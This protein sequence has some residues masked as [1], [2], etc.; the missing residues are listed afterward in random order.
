MHESGGS[1]TVTVDSAPIISGG[2]NEPGGR[3]IDVLAALGYLLFATMLLWPI[4][5][6][7]VPVASDTL[8]LWAPWSQ[9]PHEPVNTPVL[10]DSS[11]LYLPWLVYGR[12]SVQSG[13]WPLWDPYSFSGFPYAAN[14]QSQLYYP[15]T[16]LLWLLPLSGHI[17]VL[18]LFNIWLAGFGTYLFTKRLG[19]SRLAAF[20][21]GIAFAGS[22]IM[23]LVTGLWGVSSV[24]GWLPWILYFADRV[25]LAR[26]VG[27]IAAAAAAVALQLVAGHLQYAVYTIFV[28]A[29]WVVWRMVTFAR[30][31]GARAVANFALRAAA[32]VALGLGAA[33]VHLA[34]LFELSALSGR[35]GAL[36]SSNSPPLNT[37]L[38]SLAPL[39][40]GD[41]GSIG[42]PLVFNDLWYAGVPVVIVAVSA[43]FAS[44]RALVW[45]WAGLAAVAIAVA[46][47]IGPFLY[48]RWL[49]GL[50]GM[51]PIRIGY[52]FVFSLAVLSALGLDG[53]LKHFRESQRRAS[54]V[55]AV[56][57]VLGA[58]A[59]L[60]ALTLRAGE[61]DEALRGLQDQQVT[62]LA[63]LCGLTIA[64]LWLAGLAATRASWNPKWVLASSALLLALLWFDLLTAVRGYNTFVQ[65]HVIMPSSPAV[66]WLRS[67]ES[68]GRMLG[69][70]VEAE[71]P[72][73]VP[74]TQVL[75]R[76][77]SVAGY[78]S[79]HTR[80][81]EDFW[82]AFDKTIARGSGSTPYANV[83]V[84]PQAYTSTAASLL[85]VQYVASTVPLSASPGMTLAYEGEI[86]IYELEPRV[87]RAYFIA[88]AEVLPREALLTGLAASDFDPTAEVL[89]SAAET[90]PTRGD[91]G[92][93]AG[94]VPAEVVQSGRNSVDVRLEA[95]SAGWLVL[96]DV[97][98]PGWSATVNGEPARVY[99]AYLV[100]RTV[101]VQAGENEVHFE[102]R[103]TTFGYSVPVSMAALGLITACALMS[104]WQRRRL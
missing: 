54:A 90:P 7:R 34:P 8:Y 52:V 98:Y 71:P 4:L 35:I 43:L 77:P 103:P 28:L 70:G 100:L 57:F 19:A 29:V 21:A 80:D 5:F 93:P 68:D 24:Y 39:F 41:G 78:D 25:L 58:L 88:N 44:P 82:A 79:L 63:V 14:S 42:S 67:R 13:E 75:Y 40:L 46:Y 72:V 81:Y 38:R 53:L 2:A 22:G 11:L 60:S 18:S 74:N 51:L 17:Q 104:V 55:L 23:Q 33:L 3:R 1:T 61:A 66:D 15:L 92:A 59:I 16:W 6:G 85:D 56:S 32:V 96:G 30:A 10:A 50:S 37:L 87:P 49:P 9:T 83:F 31:K 89:L 86:L 36:V 76:F 20:A 101:Q 62:R 69:R 84:R 64:L 27:W 97:N 47:G 91:P 12:E 73:F 102:Y 26:H 65:P 95:P 48:A 94:I 99:S 45:L